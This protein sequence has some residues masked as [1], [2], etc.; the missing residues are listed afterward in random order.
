MARRHDD[1]QSMLDRG[2]KPMKFPKP[3]E[4]ME[5]STL[6]TLWEYAVVTNADVASKLRI[7]AV[8][9][10]RCARVHNQHE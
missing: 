1:K 7:R 3:P 10:S 6:L 8:I 2:G 9:E 5:T 4:D